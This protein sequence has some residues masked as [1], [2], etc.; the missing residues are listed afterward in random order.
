MS[1]GNLNRDPIIQDSPG[2]AGGTPKRSDTLNGKPKTTSAGS[3]GPN[4][5]KKDDPKQGLPCPNSPY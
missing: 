2:T 5:T 1:N 4:F 3:A